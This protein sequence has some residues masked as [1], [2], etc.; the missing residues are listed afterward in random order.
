M[1]PSLTT[2][3]VAWSSISMAVDHLALADDCLKRE[4]GA[5]LRP[6][7]FYTLCRGALVAAS[8]AIW[9]LSGSRDTRLRRIQLVELLELDGLLSFLQ[10][11][12]R[13]E[14][15]EDTVS[16]EFLAGVNRRASE[17]EKRQKSL[18][19]ALSPQRGEN[20]VTRMLKDAAKVID[21]ARTEDA[22]LRR[23][24]LAEWRLA[25]ATAHARIW[26]GDIRP[27]ETVPLVGQRAKLRISSATTESYGTS[28]AAATMATSEAFKLWDKYAY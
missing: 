11:Y 3:T 13:D 7:A 6:F 24:F 5:R 4:G 16:A 8:Q 23:A 26:P 15:L 19:A 14:S 12:S 9:V 27:H 17:V 25:S 18:K 28:L 10:D 22:W 20:S 2:S 1:N 21:D